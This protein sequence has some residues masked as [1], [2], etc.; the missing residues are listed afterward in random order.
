[1]K[2]AQELFRVILITYKQSVGQTDGHWRE[3]NLLRINFQFCFTGVISV[4]V[5]FSQ[6]GHINHI[7]HF[8]PHYRPDNKGWPMNDSA[9]NAFC[10][11]VHAVSEFVNKIA[12]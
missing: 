12:F 5:F 2:I 11:A 6:N 3:Y 7:P 8:G 1:M 10:R 4:L 9:V